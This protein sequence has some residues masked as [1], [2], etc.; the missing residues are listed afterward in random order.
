MPLLPIMGPTGQHQEQGKR[1]E[2]AD[3]GRDQV[4]GGEVSTYFL[5]ANLAVRKSSLDG[6]GREIRVIF[7]GAISQVNEKVFGV[8]DKSR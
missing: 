5:S 3:D 7:P 8:S 4:G 6:G 2:L 1:I